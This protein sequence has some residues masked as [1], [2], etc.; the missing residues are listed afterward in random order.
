VREAPTRAA[1]P[2]GLVITAQG[3]PVF[4]EF[5]ANKLATIDPETMAIREH[6]LPTGAAATASSARG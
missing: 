3:V 1:K 2:Y 4:C 6:L 5:G